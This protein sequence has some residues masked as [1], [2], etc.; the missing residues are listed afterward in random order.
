MDLTI[1]RPCDMII[2]SQ[3]LPLPSPPQG[4]WSKPGGRFPTVLSSHLRV[5][6]GMRWGR[7]AGGGLHLTCG[8]GQYDLPFS[9]KLDID[10]WQ[11]C[12]LTPPVRLIPLLI[13][14][15]STFPIRCQLTFWRCFSQS[16]SRSLVKDCAEICIQFHQGFNMPHKCVC[17]CVCANLFHCLLWKINVLLFPIALKEAQKC[18]LCCD[19]CQDVIISMTLILD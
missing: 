2:I 1:P 15:R 18:H 5:G 13:S 14:E 4:H 16:A 19:T 7:C 17:L 8:N 9:T 10:L 6:G 12:L 11:K 3:P